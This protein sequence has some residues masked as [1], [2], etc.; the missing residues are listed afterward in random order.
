M[1]ESWSGDS[2]QQT[3]ESPLWPLKLE[4]GRSLSL[5]SPGGAGGAGVELAH[6]HCQEL[7]ITFRF[8]HG[9]KGGKMLLAN[10]QTFTLAPAN[11]LDRAEIFRKGSF[12]TLSVKCLVVVMIVI[13]FSCVRE[14]YWVPYSR[15][16]TRGAPWELSRVEWT[17]HRN[18]TNTKGQWMEQ[19]PFLPSF[20]FQCLFKFAA[21]ILVFLLRNSASCPV[22]LSSEWYVRRRLTQSCPGMINDQLC[23][24]K[25]KYTPVSLHREI[26]QEA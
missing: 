20:P 26:E 10:T 6:W 1:C 23:T 3:A 2:R 17:P 9:F 14:S 12:L 19:R 15:T 18:N 25:Y 7:L 11:Y 16:L 4:W 13:Q 5:S 24:E 8:L 22:I 21:A